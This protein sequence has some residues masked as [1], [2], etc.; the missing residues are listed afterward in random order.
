M[1][2]GRSAAFVRAVRLLER[3]A[4]SDAPV[5]IEGET[6]TGKELAA[7][8]VHYGGARRAGPFVPINCGAIPDAL[9]ENELFGHE[10]GAF[11]DARGESR[12]CV[13]LAHGGTLFLDEI[14]ALTPKGQVAL[15]RFLQDR[16]YRPLGGGIECRADVRVVAAS[17]ASLERLADRGTFRRDLLFRLKLLFIE[18]PRLRVRTGDVPLLTD[19]FVEECSRAYAVPPRRVDP[20][21][22][23]WLE[24]QEWPGNVRELQNVVHRAVLLCDGPAIAVADLAAV[25]EDPAAAD[26][27]T[28]Q[29]RSAKAAAMEAFHR[30]FLLE[31]IRAAAGNLS[32]AARLCGADRRV[33]GR[34]LKRYRIDPSTFRSA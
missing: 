16:T 1:M 24:R 31:V 20:E 17:N 14:D 8:F 15:L 5:L 22:R 10:R 7:R 26:G 3:F 9:L 25:D 2:I 21:A 19:H 12:G 29:Y 34:L 11:T 18:M 6:G 4:A 28:R 23:A 30:R 32:F 13:A 27:E 33:L